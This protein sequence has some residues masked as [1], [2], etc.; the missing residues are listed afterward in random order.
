MEKTGTPP[1]R[2]LDYG[3]AR[4]DI[5][6]RQTT[7][8]PPL[9][10]GRYHQR[11]LDQGKAIQHVPRCGCSYIIVVEASIHLSDGA[12]AILQEFPVS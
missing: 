1:S 4:I 9:S 10:R 2:G 5:Q 8:Y 11:L 6:P 3:S 12:S 7:A